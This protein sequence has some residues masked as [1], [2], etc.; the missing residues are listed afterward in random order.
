MSHQLSLK[1]A[2]KQWHGSLSAY[3]T[4]FV[5]SIVLTIISFS[6]VVSEV[7][8]ANNTMYVI[9]ALALAQAVVQLLFFM[10]LGQEDK[11][12]WESLV[13]YFMLLVLLI[14]SV[15][16]LWIISD[17]NERVMSNMKM[18]MPHD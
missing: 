8:A 2:Q 10:H 16:S 4:G 9:V 15:G 11:P 3:L 6:V 18:E 12:K 7:F 14:I 17:L 5:G 13:F 1:E